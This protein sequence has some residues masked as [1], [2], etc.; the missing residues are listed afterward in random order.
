MTRRITKTQSSG[1]Y[2]LA[3]HCLLLTRRH[4]EID[5]RSGGGDG[6]DDEDVVVGNGNGSS[7]TITKT[8]NEQ[9]VY[10]HHQQHDHKILL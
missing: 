10:R 7:S 1:G 5:R 9:A 4:K 6:D 2:Q 8:Q 3:L